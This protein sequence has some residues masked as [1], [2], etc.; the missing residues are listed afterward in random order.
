MKVQ[1][2]IEVTYVLYIPIIF[3]IWNINL[4]Y[5]LKYISVPAQGRKKWENKKQQMNAGW[6]PEYSDKET[7]AVVVCLLFERRK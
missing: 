6:Q 3:I 7:T 5:K 2:E 1:N 4:Q